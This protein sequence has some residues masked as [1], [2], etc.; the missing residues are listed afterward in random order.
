MKIINKSIGNASF[1]NVIQ[2]AYAF[3]SHYHLK[4]G[5]QHSAGLPLLSPS[6]SIHLSYKWIESKSEYF[7]F[8]SKK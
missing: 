1:R 8:Y 5:R 6:N 4:R 7:T 3:V 2:I